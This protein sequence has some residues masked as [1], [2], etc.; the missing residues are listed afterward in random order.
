MAFFFLTEGKKQ[1]TFFSFFQ[2]T[3]PVYVWEFY[4]LSDKTWPMFPTTS[5]VTR[6]YLGMLESIS[7]MLC[8]CQQICT[9]LGCSL[10]AKPINDS[11]NPHPKHLVSVPP[12]TKITRARCLLFNNA[13]KRFGKDIFYAVSLADLWGIIYVALSEHPAPKLLLF[14]IYYRPAA[15]QHWDIWS[16]TSLKTNPMTKHFYTFQ[17]NDKKYSIRLLLTGSEFSFYGCQES[18]L[19]KLIKPACQEKRG[20]E[21]RNVNAA[22]WEGRVMFFWGMKWDVAGGKKE[23]VGRRRS[24]AYNEHTIIWGIRDSTWQDKSNQN[25]ETIEAE[26]MKKR[27]AI[28]VLLRLSALVTLHGLTEVMQETS[29]VPQYEADLRISINSFNTRRE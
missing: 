29:P 10:I 6:C 12:Y 28:P 16:F 14:P 9:E 20:K 15:V 13:N 4:G 11:L 23:E 26:R 5:E 18:H 24:L 25:A 21:Q 22:S 2:F 7:L 3:D 1:V 19:V 8:S 27:Q 17:R